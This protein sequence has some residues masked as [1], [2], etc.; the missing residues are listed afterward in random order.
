M[1]VEFLKFDSDEAKQIF[2]RGRVGA[3]EVG[4]LVASAGHKYLSALELFE[5]KTGI[6]Y[7]KEMGIEAEIGLIAEDLETKLWEC[8]SPDY[9][10]FKKNLRSNNRW[11]KAED[12]DEIAMC[13]GIEVYNINGIQYV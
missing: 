8:Y 11:R 9:N 12:V 5:I 6:S 2:R 3:S 13:I 4:A 7:P 1:A 10:I